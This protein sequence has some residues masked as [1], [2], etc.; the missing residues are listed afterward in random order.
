[1]AL[2]RRWQTKQVQH[3]SRASGE[4]K[5]QVCLATKEALHLLASLT[6]LAATPAVCSGL[7]SP[8]FHICRTDYIIQMGICLHTFT[9]RSA[10]GGV[11]GAAGPRQSIGGSESGSS[12]A[13]LPSGLQLLADKHDFVDKHTLRAVDLSSTK[14][15]SGE[16]PLLPA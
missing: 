9:V 7:R 14:Y 1:M 13:V 15:K 5:G 10:L 8:L 3:P 4:I 6:Y 16:R 12:D 11:R 2:S